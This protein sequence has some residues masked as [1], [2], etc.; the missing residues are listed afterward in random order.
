MKH[1]VI[2][3]TLT[4]N[5][6]PF[7][8]THWHMSADS[9]H[10]CMDSLLPGK[11]LKQAGASPIMC[12]GACHIK[13]SSIIKRVLMHWSWFSCQTLHAFAPKSCS[14][15]KKLRIYLSYLLIESGRS[16]FLKRTSLGINFWIQCKHLILKDK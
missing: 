5:I 3:S 7:Q 9:R 6:H 15:F 10:H 1:H 14:L 16:Q 2:E 11:R 12:C 13:T 8:G 4:L